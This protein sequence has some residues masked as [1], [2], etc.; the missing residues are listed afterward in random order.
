MARL[1]LCTCRHGSQRMPGRQ[2]GRQAAQRIEKPSRGRQCAISDTQ[3][4]QEKRGEGEEK[5][6]G[7]ERD[8]EK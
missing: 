3:E 5:D 8:K 4:P 2:A 1:A 7:H 6:T